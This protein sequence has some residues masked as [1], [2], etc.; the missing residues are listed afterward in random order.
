MAHEETHKL[1]EFFDL[2]NAIQ[3]ESVFLNP[4]FLNEED[5]KEND[6]LIKHFNN[7][8]DEM[9]IGTLRNFAQYQLY[10]WRKLADGGDDSDDGTDPD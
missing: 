4:L 8:M 7:K 1:K 2:L 5:Q 3:K 9:A 10:D 6:M